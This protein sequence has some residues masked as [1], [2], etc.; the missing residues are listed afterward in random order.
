M[1]RIL[2]QYVAERILEHSRDTFPQDNAIALRDLMLDLTARSVYAGH[3]KIILRKL[4]VAVGL[5]CFVIRW[6]SLPPQADV[7]RAETLAHT[8]ISMAR[9]DSNVCHISL[10]ARSQ[11]RASPGFPLDRGRGSRDRGPAGSEQVSTRAMMLS[12]CH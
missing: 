12:R 7:P 5:I 9:L 8:P 4:F 11:H 3:S 2:G 10:R 1:S 6:G